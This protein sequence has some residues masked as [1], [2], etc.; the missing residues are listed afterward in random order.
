MT[1]IIHT[2]DLHLKEEGDERWEALIKIIN[3]CKEKKI[4]YLVISGDL[5][6]KNSKSVLRNKLREL[7]ENIDFKVLIIPGNHDSDSF[8]KGLYFGDN[9]NI[10]CEKPFEIFEE[11]VRFIGIPYNDISSDALLK[12]IV[13]VNELIDDKKKNIFL[14]HGDLADIV[15]VQ[16]DM[17][18]EGDKR[19]MPARLA[20]FRN[21][22]ADYVL[23]GHYHVDFQI[24]TL[25]EDKF[26]VYP[27]SPVSTTKKET[28]RRVVN[29]LDIGKEPKTIELDT[30]YYSHRN[31]FLTPELDPL[32][33]IKK[34]VAEMQ[35][36]SKK[37]IRL[38]G[39]ISEEESDFR[40]KLETL[41]SELNVNEI[42]HEYLNV[43]NITGTDLYRQFTEKLESKDADIK[44]KA[45]NY[46][47]QAASEVVL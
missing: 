13:D 29:F 43:E 3:L 36:D 16:G 18:D 12:I 15:H 45:Y 5:F 8:S 44:E 38:P 34:V 14:F 35:G 11:Q 40:R 9:V 32:D 31:V 7:F 33:V 24:F 28:G 27:G 2:S 25:G 23:A 19:Y 20:Y 17:G 30:L 1:S 22:H 4:D 6:H 39:F 42:K 21:T 10:L 37:I 41:K 47:L 26:F 46:F